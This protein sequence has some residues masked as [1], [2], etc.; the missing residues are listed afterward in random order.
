MKNYWIALICLFLLSASS[1]KK[2][3]LTD[4]GLAKAVTPLSN[5]DYLAGNTYHLFDTLLMVIDHYNL[6]D[7][8]NMAGTFFAPTDVSISSVLT[9]EQWTSLD[10]L[11]AHCTSKF[12]TQYCFADTSLSLYSATTIPVAHPS[13]ADTIAGLKKTAYTYLVV[14]TDFTYYTLQYIK[15]NGQLDGINGPVGSD[16]ADVVLNCQTTGVLTSNGKTNLNVLS[17]NAS[18]AIR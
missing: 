15:I 11:Y 10:S 12:I 16:P 8:V 9:A 18:L 6:K 13:W 5:Y 2:S 1:C 3:Y 14:N 4:G 17:G 7:S